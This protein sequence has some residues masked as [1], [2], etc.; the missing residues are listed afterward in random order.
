VRFNAR[1]ANLEAAPGLVGPARVA[2]RASQLLGSGRRGDIAVIDQPDLDEETAQRLVESGVAAVVNASGMVSAR[3][4]NLGPAVLARAGVA[5]VDGVGRDGWAAVVDGRPVRVVDGVVHLGGAVVA[6]GRA[7][8]PED[9]QRE[10]DQARSGL[11]VQLDALVHNAGE[12]LRREQ[13]LLFDGR[14]LPDLTTTVAGRPAIVVATADPRALGA[15][16]RIVR[17][18]DPVVLA[19]GRAA[20]DLL[21]Y[22]W[23]ADVVIAA[24]A[25]AEGLPSADALR[26]ARD[27][28]VV[29]APGASMEEIEAAASIER[30]GLS[31]SRV[32]TAATAED[33]ALLLAERHG[34]SSVVGVGL[35]TRLEDFL[36]RR[37]AG[38]AS[39]FATRLKVGSHLVD[40]SVVPDLESGG[41]GT[42]QLVALLGVGL[43]AVLLAVGVTPVGQEWADS[44]GDTLGALL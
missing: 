31:P 44:I 24:L 18:R 27:V 11:S 32:E 25:H 30:L 4:P 6:R 15:L 16:R 2:R 23:V 12:F 35:R 38:L 42:G 3:F 8:D 20:D 28:V 41:T 7:V 10:M 21:G 43:A 34:A 17:D 33:V 40:A 5:M 22:G 19:V 9:L 14:G 36:D 29:G 13:D 39:T 1:R 26:A 37:E